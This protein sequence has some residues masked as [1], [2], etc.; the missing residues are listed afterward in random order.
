MVTLRDPETGDYSIIIETKDAESPRKLTVKLDRSFGKK[1]LC[2]WYSDEKEQF[3]RKADIMPR[4]GRFTLTLQP[5]AVYSLSTTRGQ[6]KGGFDAVPA[7][8][9]FPIPY[10][11]DFASAKKRTRP[12]RCSFLYPAFWARHCGCI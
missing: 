6:Q 12:D 8:E 9:P 4:G 3:V 7:A 5:N 11:E 1:P 2:V 10:Q